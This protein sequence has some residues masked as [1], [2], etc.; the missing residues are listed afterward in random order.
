MAAHE[1]HHNHPVRERLKLFK[2]PID[3][4]ASNTKHDSAE[5]L[6]ATGHAEHRDDIPRLR[7]YEEPTLLEIFYD[8]FFAANYTVFSENREV[9]NHSNF[10][11]YIGYFCLLWLTWFLTTSYDVR[12]VTDSIFERTTRALQLG[13]LVGFAVVAPKFEPDNQ[14][15]QVMRTM[16][17]ILMFSRAILAVEYGSTL[18]HL[19]RYK[20]CLLPLWISIATN[21]ITMLIYL[22]ITFRF[23]DSKNSKVH[24]TWYILSGAEGV[25]TLVISY[26]WP[27][28]GFSKTHLIKRLTLLTVMMLGDGLINIAKEVVTIVKTPDAWDARTIG[29][30]TAGVATVYFV[31]LIYFDW[32]R[33]SFY[34]PPVRQLAWT[35]LHLPFHL[36]LVLFMQA[37]TQYIIWGK[38]MGILKSINEQ[39]FNTD[40]AESP[41]TNLTTASMVKDMKDY[42]D[43]LFERYPPKMQQ[44][45]DTVNVAL[46]NISSVPDSIWTTIVE[47]GSTGN[48]SEPSQDAWD[49]IN[50]ISYSVRSITVSLSNNIFQV[51]GIDVTKDEVQFEHAA[52]SDV[53]SGAFTKQIDNKIWRRYRLVFAYGY[54]AAGCCLIFMAVLSVVS[55]TTRWKPW[56]IIRLV[57]LIILAIG[58]GL[59]SLLWYAGPTAEQVENDVGAVDRCL[60]YLETP[61]VLITI[62]VV[63]TVVLVLTHIGGNSAR[64]P[65]KPRGHNNSNSN[66]NLFSRKKKQ[67]YEPVS[68]P[69]IPGDSWGNRD[70]SGNHHNGVHGS[71]D[72]QH[73]SN[74]PYDAQRREDIGVAYSGSERP[75]DS[76]DPLKHQST[77]Y[78]GGGSHV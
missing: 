16:S 34:L 4:Y 62:F 65:N 41:T 36:S 67:A 72:Q 26:V 58:T 76:Y 74:Y 52:Q 51:F 35:T 20:K 30:I 6:H 55:R 43:R 21:V 25:V 37:F 46:Q 23:S 64:D 45:N 59:V 18:W 40:N 14:I 77:E 70:P 9:T 27:V 39:L 44:I 10:K 75:P 3:V 7:R 28:M 29:L 22:G 63:Y 12:F 56:P 47:L 2:S 78:R 38:V 66:S 73:Q 48:N 33:S 32:L 42:V 68:V 19:R 50:K 53:K 71:H 8:L 54:I 31:F 60:S 15:A 57:I 1:H 69:M 24:I 13:V 11:A 17:L 5:E 61:W 49:D